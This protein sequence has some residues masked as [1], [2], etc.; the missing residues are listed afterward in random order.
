MKK[1]ILYIFPIIAIL[2]IFLLLQK[3]NQDP[4][5]IANT[6]KEPLAF[7]ANQT[8]CPKCNMFLVGKKYTAEVITSDNKTH[9][10]DDVGCMVLWVEDKVKNDKELVQWAYSLDSKKWIN[11]RDAFYSINDKTPMHYGFGAFENSK[12]ESISY[13]EMKLRMLRGENMTNPKIRKKILGEN[14]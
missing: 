12:K 3:I 1:A 4:S 8:Q 11:A 5:Q 7:K 14:K 13:D 10:F 2:G 6:K 9:F